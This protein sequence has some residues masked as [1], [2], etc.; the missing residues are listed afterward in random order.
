MPKL[1]TPVHSVRGTNSDPV[2]AAKRWVKVNLDRQDLDI[3]TS[4]SSCRHIL[5]APTSRQSSFEASPSG[6][7]Q[8]APRNTQGIAQLSNGCLRL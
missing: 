5:A 8:E 3:L 4:P 7:L 2:R 1:F 6:T